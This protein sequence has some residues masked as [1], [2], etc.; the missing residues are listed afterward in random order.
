MKKELGF[1]QYTELLSYMV[2]ESTKGGAI[3]PADFERVFKDNRPVIITG[4]SGSGKTTTVR[5]MLK[6]W[7]GSV[8]V[9]DVTGEKKNEY[10][11]YRKLDLGRF[12]A[13]EW[14]RG[15]QKVRFIPNSN[16]QISQA[17]AATIFSHLNFV[18]NSGVL[19]SWV[20]VI[21]E[22]HRFKDDANLRALLIEARKF[23]R[24]LILVT[25]DWKVYEGITKVFKPKPWEASSEGAP[26]ALQAPSALSPGPT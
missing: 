5:E 18:K 3:P 25:T 11:E 26:S 20:L 15:I 2:L 23:V 16:V 21:E 8:F 24:K 17:E 14:E 7:D 19:Q 4:E 9:L 22:G 1:R 10:P 13:L 6:R 12:F